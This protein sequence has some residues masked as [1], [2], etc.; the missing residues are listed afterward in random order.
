MKLRIFDFLAPAVMVSVCCLHAGA[1]DITFDFTGGIHGQ[2]S[3]SKTASGYTLTFSSPSP[4]SFFE[5]DSDGLAIGNI[6]GNVVNQFQIVLTGGPVTDALLF[7]NYQVGFVAG[8]GTRAAEPFTLTGGTGSSTNNNLASVATFDFDGTFSIS[9]GQTVIFSSPGTTAS[10]VLSQINFMT[11]TVVPV[12]EPSTYFLGTIAA[13]TM[14]WQ[15][16]KRRKA[17]A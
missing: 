1:A 17:S 9:Q 3:F 4:T 13:A 10:N 12:P 6:H 11:F 8:T 2:S 14:T 7:K 15:V 5:G 16:R